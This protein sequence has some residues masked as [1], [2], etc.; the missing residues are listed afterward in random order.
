MT[1]EEPDM[2]AHRLAE[3]IVQRFKVGDQ[4]L[5]NVV[6]EVLIPEFT[7]SEGSRA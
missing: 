1:A 2:R 3:Q 4:S 5:Y 6:R 7:Q